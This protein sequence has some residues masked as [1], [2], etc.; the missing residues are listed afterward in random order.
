M[1]LLPTL[2]GTSFSSGKPATVVFSLSE[3][4]SHHS[5]KY[6][7]ICVKDGYADS[8]HILVGDEKQEVRDGLEIEG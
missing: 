3:S 5:I 1:A 7:Y 8:S 6:R 4:D 2:S